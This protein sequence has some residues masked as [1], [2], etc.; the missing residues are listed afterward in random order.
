MDNCRDGLAVC[1]SCQI[2]EQP[3]SS[4][5]PPF[6]QGRSGCS[7]QLDRVAQR[8]VLENLRQTMLPRWDHLVR[9][10]RGFGPGVSLAEFLRET[11]V[12]LTDIYR[13]GRCWTELRRAAGMPCPQAVD[14]EG[15]ALSALGRVLHWDDIELLAMAGRLAGG[16]AASPQGRDLGTHRRLLM[17]LCAIYGADVPGQLEQ[18]FHRWCNHSALRA[19]LG[20]LVSVLRDRVCHQ[21][22]S[23]A[24]MIR[25][26]VP[27]N[28][29]CRYSR[30]EI[31]AAHEVVKSGRLYQPREGIYFDHSSNHDLLF[32]TLQKTEREYSPSTMYEDYAISPELFHWQSQSQT[33][34]TDKAGHRYVNH[35]ELGVRPLL[36][37]RPGKKT[38]VGTTTPYLFLGPVEYVEHKGERPMNVVWKLEY[39]MPIDTFRAAKVVAG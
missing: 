8:T 14:D 35:R 29:R 11:E 39:P 18:Y 17:I 7:I 33:K 21:P 30:D 16:D 5:N 36:F 26:G 4:G 10:L 13:G 6:A 34:A 20:E 22:L 32:V 23:D 1:R 37:V 27:L 25:Q 2:D 12:D 3:R 28:V 15:E 19:E 31:M 9:E 38:E 24:G